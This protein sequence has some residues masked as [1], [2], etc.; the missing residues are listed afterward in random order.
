MQTHHYIVQ[1]L[2]AERVT[3]LRRAA[4]PRRSRPVRARRAI[5]LPRLARREYASVPAER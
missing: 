1:Q 5:R 4:S 3:E 2:A